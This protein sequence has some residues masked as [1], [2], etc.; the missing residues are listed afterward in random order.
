MNTWCALT[1]EQLKLYTQT[2]H[3][4][5]RAL[6]STDEGIQRKG[7]VLAYLTRF[8]QIC[9]Y[10]EQFL[11]DKDYHENRSGKFARLTELGEEIATHQEKVFVFTQYREMTAPIASYLEQL[12]GTQG[13][14][15]HGG[16][17]V[18]KRKA[19]VDQLQNEQGPPFFRQ[20]LIKKSSSPLISPASKEKLASNCS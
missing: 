7:L 8:K 11:G 19:L 17:P 2:V 6:Q 14:V 9:N 13:L 5:T 12:F 3:D 15:L 16:I 18:S 20:A 1:K 10:P 4:M